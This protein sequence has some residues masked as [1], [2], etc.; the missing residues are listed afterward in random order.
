[1]RVEGDGLAP[2]RQHLTSIDANS[3]GLLVAACVNQAPE[4]FDAAAADVGVMDCLRFRAS[5]EDA[6]VGADVHSDL[7]SIGAAWCADYGKPDEPDGFD[8]LR[9]YSPLHN[10]GPSKTYPVR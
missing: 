3:G 6:H 5:P 10:I 9:K 4:L 7:F 2:A 1:M 8:T